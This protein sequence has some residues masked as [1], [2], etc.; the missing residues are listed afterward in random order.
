MWRIRRW[1]VRRG[2]AMHAPH[3]RLVILHHQVPSE[4][5][6]GNFGCAIA[7]DL[8]MKA[9]TGPSEGE[10]A[11][12][13]QEARVLSVQSHVVYGYVGNK[14]AIFPLQLLGIEAD[15]I[16]TVQFSN[17]TGTASISRGSR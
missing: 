8:G 4:S 5:A 15:F 1:R 16:N 13:Q 10:A 3:A 2:K 7:D 12:R 11:G 6:N 9:E 14:S 17:H